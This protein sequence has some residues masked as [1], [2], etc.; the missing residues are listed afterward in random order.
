[1]A[2]CILLKRTCC[3]EEEKTEDRLYVMSEK[4]YKEIQ[5]LYNILLTSMRERQLED[6]EEN[7]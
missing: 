6:E 1:M 3:D 5:S 2:L 4:A 7:A